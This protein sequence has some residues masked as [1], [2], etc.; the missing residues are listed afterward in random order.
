MKKI[1]IVILIVSLAL[2]ALGVTGCFLFRHFVT[3]QIT[4]RGGMEN[5]DAAAEAEQPLDGDEH[6]VL[7][8]ELSNGSCVEF[9]RSAD[10]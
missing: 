1:L 2:A 9:R 8:M 5:P 7:S 10:Q 6:G 4:D 3:H